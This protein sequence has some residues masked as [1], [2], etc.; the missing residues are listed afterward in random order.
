MS[1]Y[2]A[3]FVLFC[4]FI[5]ISLFDGLAFR[6]LHLTHSF[7]GNYTQCWRWYK[8]AVSETKALEKNLFFYYFFLKLQKKKKAKLRKKKIHLPSHINTTKCDLTC[9]PH[10]PPSPFSA[11]YFQCCW[12]MPPGLWMYISFCSSLSCLITDFMVISPCTSYSELLN[13]SLAGFY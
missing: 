5:F 12:V 2:F 4:F 3:F 13:S 8:L 1:A 10:P 7:H 6:A 9:C 11:F